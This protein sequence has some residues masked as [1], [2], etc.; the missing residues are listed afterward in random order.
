MVSSCLP[1]HVSA[2]PSHSRYGGQWGASHRRVLVRLWLVSYNN[3]KMF[4]RWVCWTEQVCVP[5][6]VLVD[7]DIVRCCWLLDYRN[8]EVQCESEVNVMSVSGRTDRQ[9]PYCP[10]GHMCKSTNIWFTHL[11]LG[12]PDLLCRKVTDFLLYNTYLCPPICMAY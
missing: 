9:L 7:I 12:L 5:L 11:P 3:L 4:R 10:G 8:V 2:W 6:A 1:S